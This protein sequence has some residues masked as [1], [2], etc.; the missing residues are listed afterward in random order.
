MKKQHTNIPFQKEFHA[1]IDSFGYEWVEIGTNII[2][3][4]DKRTIQPYDVTKS[5]GRLFYKDFL[6]RLKKQKKSE[7]VFKIMSSEITVLRYS[8]IREILSDI[9]VIVA[10]SFILYYFIF[11]V[12]TPIGIIIDLLAIVSIIVSFHSLISEIFLDDRT[13]L[14]KR[15]GFKKTDRGFET[16]SYNILRSI[17]K[18]KCIFLL[19]SAIFLTISLLSFIYH[20]PSL[21]YVI[22]V[23]NFIGL[24]QFSLLTAF[25]YYKSKK[26]Q[27]NINGQKTTLLAVVGIFSLLVLYIMVFIFYYLPAVIYLSIIIDLLVIYSIPTLVLGLIKFNEFRKWSESIH[28]ISKGRWGQC[29]EK[30]LNEKNIA[31]IKPP[32]IKQ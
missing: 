3:N 13:L 29:S 12:F 8:V 7:W 4:L 21:I 30:I 23:F 20:S 1:A 18:S 25:Q 6:Q 11:V 26:K 27:E 2:L 9:I 10:F 19:V 31:N 32:E 24:L 5:V 14:S 17:Q 22:S 15:F 16:Y 28:T